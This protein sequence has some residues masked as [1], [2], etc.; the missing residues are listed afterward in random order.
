MKAVRV[1]LFCE[2]AAHE[3]FARAIL[4][5]LGAEV[6]LEVTVAVGTA[7]F[8]IPRLRRELRIFQALI[9]ARP[10]VPDILLILVDANAVGP[11]RRRAEVDEVLD[12]TLFVEVVVG[13][14]DPCVER[15]LLADPKSFAGRFGVQPDNSPVRRGAD[16]KTRLAETLEEAGRIVTQGGAEYADDILDA[17]DLHRAGQLVPSLGAFVDDLRATLRRMGGP[18]DEVAEE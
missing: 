10:G 17:M 6:G 2:D 16:W 1:R 11:A 8:G 3:S 4:P 12:R 13:T 9:A 14:P 7:R 18:I 5:R 15:W